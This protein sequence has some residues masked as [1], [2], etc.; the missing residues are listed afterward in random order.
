M[1][2]W[3]TACRSSR[4]TPVASNQGLTSQPEVLIPND[5]RVR[6]VRVR[7]ARRSELPRPAMRQGLP[8]T[9]VPRTLVDLASSLPEDDL[10]R[11]CHEA[12]VLYRTTPN[13]STPSYDSC[14]MRLDA[15]SSSACLSGEVPVTLSKLES[16]FLKLLGDARLPLPIT[17]KVAGGHLVDCRWPEYRLTVELD[18]YR[19]HNS[20]HSWERDRLRER[21]ARRRGDEFRRYTWTDVFEEPREMLDEL[22]VLLGSS[23]VGVH[24]DPKVRTAPMPR[25][26]SS[27]RALLRTGP[28]PR[29]RP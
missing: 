7:R 9:S 27:G 6:G 17:N 16:R 21:G 4:C 12:G 25:S 18:S 20:R 8:L 29:A 28:R 19:H 26:R 13:R 11:A 15:R 10:A 23:G 1:R 3:R 2:R 22:A 5:R 14:R 24:I